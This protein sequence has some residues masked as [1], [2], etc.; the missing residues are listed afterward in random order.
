VQ[1]VA[2]TVDAR[3]PHTVA[4]LKRP[5]AI[6]VGAEDEGLPDHWRALADVEVRIP[7]RSRTVDSLNA[8]TAAA[9]LLFE[10]VRQRAT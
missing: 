6:L 1:K 2:A 8:S 4:D 9:V 5:T 3:T 10:A 7:M